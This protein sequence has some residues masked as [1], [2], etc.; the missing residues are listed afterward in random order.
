MPR[1]S[2]DVSLVGDFSGEFPELVKE[3]YNAVLR[4]G[5]GVLGT[6][7]DVEF[8]TAVMLS[9]SDGDSR[10]ARYECLQSPDRPLR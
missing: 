3:L 8:Q 4:E 5:L 6:C 10:R 2:R 7:V 1:R 9:A